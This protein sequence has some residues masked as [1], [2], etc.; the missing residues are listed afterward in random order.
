[1]RFVLRNAGREAPKQIKTQQIKRP[2][3][4]VPGPCFFETSYPLFR[5]ADRNLQRADTVD[6]AFDLVAGIELGDAGGRSRHDE[7]AGGE[8]YL[9][10]ELPDDLGHVPD[11]LGEVT[12]L[13]L[14]A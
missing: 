2:R 14:G 8:R 6:A 10:R 11:Q 9:L 4:R 7:V 1:M 3:T 12:L 13:L 5:L